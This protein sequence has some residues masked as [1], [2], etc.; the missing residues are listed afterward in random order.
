LVGNSGTWQ[1]KK[2]NLIFV[3]GDEKNDWWYQSNKQRLY[4]RIELVGE[5][6]QQSGGKSFHIVSLSTFLDLFK[7][8]V[9]VVSEVKKEEKSVSLSAG[10]F[11]TSSKVLSVD[12]VM[13]RLEQLILNYKRTLDQLADED[14]HRFNYAT[15][16]S[17]YFQSRNI[18]EQR[19]A[20]TIQSLI[21]NFNLSLREDVLEARNTLKLLLDMNN[22]K[23]PELLPINYYSPKNVVDLEAVLEEMRNMNKMVDEQ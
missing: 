15:S 21:H 12:E 1:I 2:K 16:N 14:M 11:E 5:Y 4:P 9:E 22:K 17:Q 19:R 6:Q 10:I 20:A 7:V 18:F 3:S 13:N 23:F 8:D